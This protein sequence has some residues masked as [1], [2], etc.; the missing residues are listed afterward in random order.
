MSHIRDDVRK[1]RIWR[2]IVPVKVFMYYGAA[3]LWIFMEEYVDEL[4]AL[5]FADKEDQEEEH[6]KVRVVGNTR[7]IG[8]KR[9][10]TLE[11]TLL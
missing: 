9:L 4:I 8:L 6:R 2:V 7:P 1:L 11:Q 5:A 10:Y 3:R